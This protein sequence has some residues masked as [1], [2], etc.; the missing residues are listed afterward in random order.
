MHLNN[1]MTDD[2]PIFRLFGMAR[3]SQVCQVLSPMLYMLSSLVFR[4]LTNHFTRIIYEKAFIL[5]SLSEY[6]IWPNYCK[7]D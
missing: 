4:V 3:H 6:K 2:Y 1:Q 7:E 5:Y